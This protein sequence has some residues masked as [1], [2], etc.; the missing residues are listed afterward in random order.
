MFGDLEEFVEIVRHSYRRDVWTG[1]PDY[2]EVFVEKDAL[3]AI[4]ED[5]LVS[6]GVTLNVGRG[7]SSWSSIKAA[8]DRFDDGA[9]RSTP[10]PTGI[11][12]NA[13]AR[14]FSVSTTTR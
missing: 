4:F 13:S 8:A 14:A 2:L 9:F 10:K 12:K 3:S 5:A 1:Q 7:Y 6:Y 11:G